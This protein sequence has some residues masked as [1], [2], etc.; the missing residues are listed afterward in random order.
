LREVAGKL[1]RPGETLWGTSTLVAHGLVV[2]GLARHGRD[3]QT[4]LHA[5]WSAAKLLLYDREAVPP[6]K[7]N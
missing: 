6:R 1:A 2:R 7:V 4:G 3:V 5:M